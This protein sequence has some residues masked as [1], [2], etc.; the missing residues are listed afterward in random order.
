MPQPA[1]VNVPQAPSAV[2]VAKGQQA[3]EQQ[4]GKQQVGKQ[5]TSAKAA[6][7]VLPAGALD[8][9]RD[10]AAS[11]GV[12]LQFL[13]D[14]PA[15]ARNTIRGRATVVIKAAV[16][17]SGNVT[18]AKVESG[19]RYFGKLALAAARR[20]QFSPVKGA[21]NREWLLRFEIAQS[22]TKVSS[23]EQRAP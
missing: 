19:S 20:W 18:N 13:P 1:A 23:K 17:P 10:A 3:R 7:P 5:Q 8:S 9:R 11:E 15:K 4:A 21:A 2:P 22:G 16:D 6:K 14:I 12:I